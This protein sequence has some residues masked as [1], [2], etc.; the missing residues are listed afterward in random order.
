MKVRLAP[1][2]LSIAKCQMAKCVKDWVSNYQARPSQFLQN[3]Q[4]I[5]GVYH[6]SSISKSKDISRTRGWGF[7]QLRLQIPGS[8]DPWPSTFTQAASS[9]IHRVFGSLTQMWSG[10]S[11]LSTR[12]TLHLY[13]STKFVGTQNITGGQRNTC[14]ARVR[15]RSAASGSCS[16]FSID[17]IDWVFPPHLSSSG[18]SWA[19]NQYG[20][21]PPGQEIFVSTNWFESPT[22]SSPAIGHCQINW[23][24]LPSTQPASPAKVCLD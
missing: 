18:I 19:V 20:S 5:C 4:P 13:S 1:I 22:S 21:P 12:Y 2:M 11:T 8:L 17:G 24:T 6:C 9:Y 15:A 14:H 3:M 16:V 10:R 7:V 23:C